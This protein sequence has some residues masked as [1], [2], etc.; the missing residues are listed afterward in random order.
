M[1]SIDFT[2]D[3]FGFYLLLLPFAQYLLCYLKWIVLL[4]D[5]YYNLIS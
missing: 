4:N 2:V 1:L 3:V 5:S